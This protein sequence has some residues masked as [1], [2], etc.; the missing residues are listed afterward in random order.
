MGNL[1]IN[2]QKDILELDNFEVLAG[3]HCESSA[4]MNALNYQGVTMAESEIN[5]FASSASFGFSRKKEF[6]SLL[7]RVCDFKESFSNCT[8]IKIKI[9]EPSTPQEA[10]N[11]AKIILSKSTPVVLRVNM[12]YLPYLHGGKYGNKNTSFGWHFVTLVKIDETLGYAWVT[13]TS[14]AQLQKIKI[15]DLAKARDA[16]EGIF[17]SD[18]YSYYFDNPMNEDINYFTSFKKSVAKM[19][20]NYEN[21][22]T[23]EE[24]SMFS[25]DIE[26]IEN[27]RSIYMMEPLFFT[28]YGFI[29]EFGTGGSGF[30]NFLKQYVIIMSERYDDLGLYDVAAIIE[31]SCIKWRE[32]ALKF[33]DISQTAMSLKKDKTARYLLYKEAAEIAIEVYKAENEVYKAIQALYDKMN[34]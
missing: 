29:E 21:Y 33:K 16:K 7:L 11:S 13:D 34:K 20:S 27:G 15:T 12:R 6:P 4:M 31:K 26:N 5:G 8:G 24:I 22:N 10:Y 23:L 25:N 9:Q 2:V 3:Q 18:N 17:K 28:M 19:I 30:R 1:R 32:L 14:F